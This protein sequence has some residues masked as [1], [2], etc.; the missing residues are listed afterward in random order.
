MASLT[1]LTIFYAETLDKWLEDQG[2]DITRW[3]NVAVWKAET[4]LC[5]VICEFGELSS[6]SSDMV[7]GFLGVCKNSGHV[8]FMVFD[9]TEEGSEICTA[10]KVYNLSETDPGLLERIKAS[11]RG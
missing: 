9:E 1:D 6:R 5:R 4:R 3:H 11:R 7:D 10:A 2:Y 8:I